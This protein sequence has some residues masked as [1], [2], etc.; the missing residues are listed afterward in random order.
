M[1]VDP[2]LLYLINFPATSRP[3][4]CCASS[5]LPPIW[6]VKIRYRNH[7]AVSETHHLRP[8]VPSGKRLL[9]RL[10]HARTEAPMPRRRCLLLSP[11]L[12]LIKCAPVFILANSSCP[13][14]LVVCGVSGTCN[15]DD[16][17][18]AEKGIQRSNG[19]CISKRQ[20]CFY[21]EVDDLHSE[22]LGKHAYL[23]A[24]VAVPD[25]SQCLATSFAGTLGGF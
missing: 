24:D 3:M 2:L 13:I 17:G 20:S 19:L 7:G 21:V 14:I 22:R 9:Q 18:R 4:F 1:I 8:S 12:H 5:V 15:G 25:N 11:W 23:S 16:V 10:Q 6:G